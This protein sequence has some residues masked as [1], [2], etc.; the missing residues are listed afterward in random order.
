[1][2]INDHNLIIID[3]NT[4]RSIT[5]IKRA[6][7][8][9]IYLEISIYIK[10]C[11]L[12]ILTYHRHLTTQVVILEDDIY[13]SIAIIAN[14]VVIIEQKI[15]LDSYIHK[16]DLEKNPYIK[17]GQVHHKDDGHLQRALCSHPLALCQHQDSKDLSLHLP[18]HRHQQHPRLH[19]HHQELTQLHRLHRA[20]PLQQ[21]HLHCHHLH[22]HR[23]CQ[24]QPFIGHQQLALEHRL[25]YYHPH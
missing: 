20:A 22:H 11:N 9:N 15:G 17:R 5:N 19:Q 24:L 25:P 14:I 1:M 2:V 8:T 6:L 18:C 13:S 21:R 7:K 3:H 10:H 23:H 16:I 4:L 12:D